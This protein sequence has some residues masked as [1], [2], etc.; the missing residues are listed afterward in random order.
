MGPLKT[1]SDSFKWGRAK[2][3]NMSSCK[4]NEPCIIKSLSTFRSSTRVESG[5]VYGLIIVMYQEKMLVP[6]KS[7]KSINQFLFSKGAQRYLFTF[8]K[9]IYPITP[10]GVLVSSTYHY[11]NFRLL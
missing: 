3:I 7:N 8:K 10:L 6:C 2:A 9:S 11:L 4:L 1:T 5:R